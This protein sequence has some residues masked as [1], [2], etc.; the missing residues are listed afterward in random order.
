MEQLAKSSSTDRAAAP[1]AGKPLSIGTKL[2]AGAGESVINL[3]VN[4][5]KEFGFVIYNLT[6]GVNAVL[7]GFVLAIPRLWDAISDPLMG[8]ISDNTKSRWGRR[9]PYMLLGGILSALLMA[10]ICIPPSFL[11]SW[12]STANK[13]G[14]LG[15][16]FSAAEWAA[17][18]YFVLISILFY[19]ALTVFS[20]PYGAL[21]LEL[22]SDYGER[23][24]LMSFRTAFTYV[25]GIM[26]GWMLYA[27]KWQVW[28]DIAER[29]GAADPIK[30]GELYGT[31]VVGGFA[32]LVLLLASLIPTFFLKEVAIANPVSKPRPQKTKKMPMLETLRQTISMPTFI[33]IVL[34]Y[35][36]AFF[37][38]ILVIHLGQYIN[39]FYT[40]DG[41]KKLGLLAQAW[42]NT[43]KP[44][45][46][47]LTVFALNRLAHRVEKKIAWSACLSISLTGAILTWFMYSPELKAWEP[48]FFGISLYLHPMIIPFCLLFPGLAATLMMSYSM[49]ADVCDIDQ[50]RSGRRREGM[51]WAVFNFVQKLALSVA[52]LMTG[53]TLSIAAFDQNSI[54]QSAETI[55]SMRL[56]FTLT[57]IVSIAAAIVLVLCVPI[58]RSRLAAVHAE[59]AKRGLN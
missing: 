13:V 37:G 33:L 50:L 40:H 8:S 57:L 3:G 32:A 39:I 29:N 43:F 24:R 2:S 27:T 28:T 45:A 4:M 54:K 5:P 36:T 55:F 10:A 11:F 6:L 34:A 20:V 44:A 58:S 1:S 14:I 41:D 7:L 18:F 15:Y 51:Y 48:N 16:H 12:F 22:T 38:I 46:G 59:L 25:S 47:L 23:T 30:Q 42:A 17:A 19:T 49:I 52:L 56:W 53:F 9:K 35:T 26:L 21:T 31:W